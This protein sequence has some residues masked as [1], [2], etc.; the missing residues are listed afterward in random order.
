MKWPFW[1]NEAP[2][3]HLP[4]ANVEAASNAEKRASAQLAQTR[5]NGKEVSR[6]A[7]RLRTLR[8]ENH[9]AEKIEATFSERYE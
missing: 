8:R 4:S 3:D 1:R 5:E 6:I 7:E 9:F 2:L